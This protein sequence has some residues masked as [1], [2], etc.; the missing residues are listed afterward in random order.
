MLEVREAEGLKIIRTLLPVSS[1]P[2]EEF[3]A[4]SV[5]Q[6]IDAPSGV[7]MVIVLAVEPMIVPDTE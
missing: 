6:V 7:W 2:V 5:V 3:A 1:P 4:V